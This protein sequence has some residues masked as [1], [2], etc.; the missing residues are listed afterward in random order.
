MKPSFIS[1]T[2]VVALLAF[3]I[4]SS[5]HGQQ[6]PVSRTLPAGPIRATNA[7][8]NGMA[9]S[10]GAATTVWFEWGSDATYG[11]STDAT[12]VGSATAVACVSAPIT[13]LITGGVYHYRTVSSNS[14]GITRGFD[15]QFTTGMRI[16]T[17]G[18]AFGQVPRGLTNVVGVAAGHGHCLAIRSDGTVAA[19]MVSAPSLGVLYPNSGQTNVPAGL[20][21]VV[22]VAGGFSHSLALKEDGT[23]IAWGKYLDSTPV[24]VPLNVTNIIAIAGG[25]Y[26]SIG[27]RRDG[28]VVGWGENNYGQLNIPFGLKDVIAISSGS[29][30]NLALRADGTVV[31]W[32]SDPGSSSP[33]SG[34]TDVVSIA[35]EGWYNLALQDDGN[36]VDWGNVIPDFPKPTNLSNIVQLATGYAYAEVLRADGKLVGWGYGTQITNT[37]PGLSNLVAMAG[38]D[39]HRCGIAPVNLPPTVS[40]RT[41]SGPIGVP[42]SITLSAF[43]PNG[44][45]VVFRINSLPAKGSLYQYTATGPGA[46]IDTPGTPLNEPTRVI[47]VPAPGAYGD[48]YDTF[49]VIGNDGDFDTAPAIITIAIIPPPIIQAGY[50]SNGPT[51]SA[52]VLGF[53]GLTNTGYTVWRS[54][55][56]VTWSFLGSATQNPPGQF[57]FSD[58]T[59]TN[60]STRFYRVRSP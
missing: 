59:I 12:N 41:Y 38:G 34:T 23:V 6:A 58:Y 10:R 28:T 44:D 54:S 50:Y 8:L 56:F 9:L 17:W 42:I 25:D 51:K 16:Q 43:D 37:P 19:W 24:T 2:I 29:S 35:T 18:R 13:N 32:G 20:S 4:A 27:L 48:P 36:V 21:N 11:Y 53:T 33:P 26:H 15:V 14:V 22:A 46:L 57:T 52:F 3:T 55:D 1:H 49:T 39:Y 60:A 7:V 31:V 47:L 45:S 5:S 30:H 40:S